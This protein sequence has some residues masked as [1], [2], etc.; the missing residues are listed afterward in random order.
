M[1]LCITQHSQSFIKSKKLTKQQVE[2]VKVF[3]SSTINQT[4]T[5]R[6][7]ACGCSY[8]GEGFS[9]GLEFL[10]IGNVQP[11]VKRA[12]YNL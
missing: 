8:E 6:D 12:L 1:C 9:V 7:E 3:L 11:R 10:L 4:S 2:Q 5:V